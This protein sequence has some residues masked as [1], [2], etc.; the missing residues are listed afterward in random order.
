[1]SLR[2]AL[3]FLLAVM[4]T[5]A[6][7]PAIPSTPTPETVAR[8]RFEPTECRGT[9]PAGLDTTCGYTLVPDYR[10]EQMTKRT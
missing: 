10:S 7:T 8:P 6:C 1:M 3:T 9:F 2:I 4:L 5:S